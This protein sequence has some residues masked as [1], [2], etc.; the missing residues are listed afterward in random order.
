MFTRMQRRRI[1]GGRSQVQSVSVQSMCT[2]GGQLVPDI[3]LTG[4]RRW[5]QEGK[6]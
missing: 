3:R 2:A 5:E 1:L 4:W 6:R